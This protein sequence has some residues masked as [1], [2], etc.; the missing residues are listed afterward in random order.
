MMIRND[1]RGSSLNVYLIQPRS[2]GFKPIS[3]GAGI[4]AMQLACPSHATRCDT[5]TI[6]IKLMKL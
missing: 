2:S 1:D 4:A 5:H 3:A 6:K